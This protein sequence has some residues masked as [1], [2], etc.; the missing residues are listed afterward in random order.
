MKV[1]AFVL[2]LVFFGFFNIAI[3]L[4]QNGYSIVQD[5]YGPIVRINV[6]EIE[7]WSHVPGVK[8][9]IEIPA[10][11]DQA[12]PQHAVISNMKDVDGDGRMDIF[13]RLVEKPYSRI[14][15]FDDQG[16]QVWITERLAPGSGDESG[17]PIIDLD[18]DGRFELI[19]S[20]WAATYCLDAN[21]GLIIWKKE[22][23]KGGHPGP[24]TWDYPMVVGHF[25]D[26]QKYAVAIRV[27]LKMIC[28][29]HK[30][31]EIW[32]T[33]ISG[34]DYGHAMRHGDVDGDGLD[35]IFSSRNGITEAF[36]HD[37]EILWQDQTQ[38]NHSDN[39]AICDFN[40]DGVMNVIYDHDGCGGA[41]PLYIVDGLTGKL[42]STIDYLKEGMTHCQ[43]FAFGDFNTDSPGLELGVSAKAGPVLL[44]SSSG[45]LL[46]KR[47]TPNTLI[48]KG[49]WDGDGVLDILVFAI[50]INLEPV[51]SVWN[52]KGERLYAMSFLPAPVRSHATMCGPG[53]GYDG[54]FDL[55]GNGKANILMAY[56]PWKIGYQPQYLLHVE[57]FSKQ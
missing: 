48:T 50:G 37:G 47:E 20:Q 10:E 4:A 2:G 39:F 46:W 51:W 18:N 21:T 28:L 31:K 38:K 11:V 52:G 32:S 44:Y 49:D 15:R 40:G 13:C 12:L 16:N 19:T 17:L 54:Y 34:S 6:E 29:D 35:E 8:Q 23:D 7:D 27:G 26:P 33:P 45:K 14:V 43:G 57:G 53:L 42:K 41:G 5:D 55:D 56:G 36:T 1:Y 25:N 9:C 30:G 22:L 3:T 24:G